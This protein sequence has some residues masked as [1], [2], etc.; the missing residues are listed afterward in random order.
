[1]TAFRR[2]VAAMTAA[3]VLGTS[4]P[5]L[6]QSP[7]MAPPLITTDEAMSASVQQRV[8]ELLARADVRDALAARG[9][10]SAQVEARVAALSDSEARLLAEQLDQLPAGASSVVGVLFAVFIILLITD[11]LGLTKVFPFTRTAR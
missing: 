1:M 4:F 7:S 10:D 11:L 9:V 8:G 6:A 3:C 5:V 2:A